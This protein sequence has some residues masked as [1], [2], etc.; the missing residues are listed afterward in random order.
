MQ[1]TMRVHN[2]WSSQAFGANT[3]APHVGPITGP[4]FLGAWARRFGGAGTV[5]ILEDDAAVV[6]LFHSDQ[7]LE[8]AGEGDVT[9]Y[10][11]P[12]G[13]NSAPLLTEYLVGLDRPTHFRFD[14][15]PGEAAQ[16]V[17]EAVR[18]AG[19]PA[20]PS[21]H[22]V[23]PVVSLP[24]D[25]EVFLGTLGKK[26][27]HEMRR[28][29]RR[30]ESALGPA[31]LERRS[32]KEAVAAFADMHRTSTGEKGKFMDEAREAFFTDLHLE[33]DGVIDVLVGGDGDAHAMSFGFEDDDTLYLYNS[34]YEPASREHNPGVVLLELLIRM[35]IEGGRTRLDLLKGDEPYKFRLGAEARPLFLIEGV[36]GG[37]S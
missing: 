11:S 12:R 18:M 5:T 36:A 2:D 28:K 23:V 26:E 27:R 33:A 3:V 35:A 37:P 6:P 29:R 13:Q 1:T 15:L 31:H 7:G 34:A 4:R 30:F 22:E 24:D 21:Q 14:S 25:Y 8:F 9:D 32:G 20:D 19:L 10:H 17:V 16:V